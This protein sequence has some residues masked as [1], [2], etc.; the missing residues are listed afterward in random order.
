MGLIAV[1]KVTAFR[2]DEVTGHTCISRA[3][4]VWFVGERRSA[5]CE[6]TP[7]QIDMLLTTTEP[8]MMGIG[9]GVAKADQTGEKYG[10]FMVHVHL[11]HVSTNAAWRVLMLEQQFPAQSRAARKATPLFGP[12][13]GKSFTPSQLDHLLPQLLQVV[14]RLRPDL[15]DKAHIHRYTYSWHSFRIA[16][17]CALR[18]LSLQDGSRKVSDAT[19]QALCRWSSPQSLQVYA[20][21][22]PGDYAQLLEQAGH[23]RFNPI[24]AATLWA[25]CPAIDD[26]SRY[27][28]AESLATHMA[29]HTE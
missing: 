19:I 11:R 20:R 14:V 5:I 1:L 12:T 26:D 8:V 22:D 2:K 9:P 4:V 23:A 13:V 3:D 24:Q 10:N 15:L 21:I 7:E 16:L 27:V 28:F 17:A 18:S 6:P 25:E 29:T